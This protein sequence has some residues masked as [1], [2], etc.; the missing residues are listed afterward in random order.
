MGAVRL[1][2]G[3]LPLAALACGCAP[4]DG[5]ISWAFALAPATS[6]SLPGPT[7]VGA[8]LD[9]LAFAMAGGRVTGDPPHATL[10]ISLTSLPPL[11]VPATKAFYQFTLLVEDAKIAPLGASL[12]T[13]LWNALSLEGAAWAH[14]EATEVPMSQFDTDAL[15]RAQLT[16]DTT[17]AHLDRVGGGR[18]DIIV[19]IGG[20]Y[21]K[22]YTVLEG[23]IGNLS[24]TTGAA[25]AAAPAHVH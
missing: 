9:P 3:V 4:S 24:D 16:P 18:V 8:T 1:A 5:V 7:E 17:G 12:P 6:V 21:Y 2:L 20:V 23:V 22:T 10:V 14:G 25:A 15:G 11:G 19:P 13:R